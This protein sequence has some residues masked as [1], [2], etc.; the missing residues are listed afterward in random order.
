[1]CF[2][3]CGIAVTMAK[4]TRKLA[5]FLSLVNTVSKYLMMKRSGLVMETEQSF[6]NSI[7]LRKISS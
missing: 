6:E 1:M 3:L 4:E 7:S 5:L 2:P